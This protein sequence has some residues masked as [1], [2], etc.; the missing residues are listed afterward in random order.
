MPLIFTPHPNPLPDDYMQGEGIC[1]IVSSGKG[2]SPASLLTARVEGG[3]DTAVAV[4]VPLHEEVREG[5][6]ERREVGSNSLIT[7][8][9]VH[10]PTD[11]VQSKRGAVYEEKRME[12][13]GTWTNLVEIDLL[14]AGEP[15]HTIG[16]GVH[17][18][19]LYLVAHG[20]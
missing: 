5:Y 4:R 12:L 15:M 1:E 2:D 3:G 19:C 10:S 7:A 13:M 8:I 17:S 9:E 11:M 18:H 14:R 6:L 16:N 20:G